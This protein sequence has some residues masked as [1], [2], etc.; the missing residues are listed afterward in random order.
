MKTEE[1]DA[2]NARIVSVLEKI[3]WR[4]GNA[5]GRR[6]VGEF[7]DTI[8]AI[9]SSSLDEAKPEVIENLYK[10]AFGQSSQD[11]ADERR[12]THLH[13]Y[14]FNLDARLG[15][16]HFMEQF[17]DYEIYI[18]TEHPTFKVWIDCVFHMECPLNGG[19]QAF[20]SQEL[21]N[22]PLADLKT[23]EPPKIEVTIRATEAGAEAGVQEG[24]H[25]LMGNFVAAELVAGAWLRPP[26]LSR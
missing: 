20:Y 9:A 4:S 14:Y 7:L 3:L 26:L 6:T 17:I 12:A 11:C 23:Y 10:A 5:D 21:H 13:D 25:W 19:A 18:A 2:L 16:P 1:R 24:Y 15:K 8:A 22:T